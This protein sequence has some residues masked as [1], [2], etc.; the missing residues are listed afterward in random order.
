M[1]QYGNDVQVSID[2]SFYVPSVNDISGGVGGVGGGADQVGGA[3]AAPAATRFSTL[4][5]IAVFFHC[6]FKVLAILAYLLLGI[7]F[8]DFVTV[9][10]LVILLS[11]FD[12]WVTKNVTGRLLVG[13]RWW[14]EV[15][16][17]GT[18]EWIFE[19]LEGKRQVVKVELLV[20]WG[21][22]LLNPV[23]W[24]VLGIVCILKININWIIVVII[25]I[26]LSLINLFGY[27]KCATEAR[28]RLKM[29][30]QEA[31]NGYIKETVKDAASSY[32]KDAAS[33][34]VSGIFSSPKQ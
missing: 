5:P 13:L 33:S 28:K 21:A 23:I 10:I 6:F 4:H 11:V 15:R 20:F 27:I 29:M 25:V 26:A 31:A 19:S 9:F 3:A 2:D 16:E 24:V 7:F 12:F 32:M 34:M 17:D 8:D 14:N 1:D 18:N 30:A 22:L